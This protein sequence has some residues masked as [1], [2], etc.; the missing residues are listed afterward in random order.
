MRTSLKIRSNNEQEYEVVLDE[1]NHHRS[2]KD[3]VGFY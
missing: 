3:H 2:R 1:N